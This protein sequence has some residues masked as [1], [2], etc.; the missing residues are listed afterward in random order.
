MQRE[1][2]AVRRISALK[3]FDKKELN[4]IDNKLC[5]VLTTANR[6]LFESAGM[7]S[8][9]GEQE[10]EGREREGGR[11][12]PSQLELLRSDR[13]DSLQGKGRWY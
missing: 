10:S 11:S 13:K 8:S 6:D 7:Q 9:C 5:C 3:R 4:Y 2:K 1:G 12:D